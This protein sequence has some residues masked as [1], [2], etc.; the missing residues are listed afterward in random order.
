MGV[1]A[2][3]DLSIS[4]GK[5]VSGV[6]KELVKAVSCQMNAQEMP[7]KAEKFSIGLPKHAINPVMYSFSARVRLKTRLK[8]AFV[9]AVRTVTRLTQGF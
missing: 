4:R 1:A 2:A 5:T 6:N 3:P 7:V 8:P 9:G